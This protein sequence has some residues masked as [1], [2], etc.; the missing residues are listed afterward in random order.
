V[1]WLTIGWAIWFGTYILNDLINSEL[2][3]L[4]F[5]IG[6]VGLIGFV[7]FIFNLQK[8]IRLGSKV[9]NSRLRDVLNNEMHQI[10]KY[11]SAYVGVKVLLAT[12][13]LFFVVSLFYPI[14][15]KLVCELTLYSGVLSILI[16]GLIY[17]RD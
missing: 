9:N 14:S 6:F 15:A 3:I 1:K 5:F 8:Y 13:S 7:V 10:Y 16:S 12:I 11:K 17:N 4:D 2:F